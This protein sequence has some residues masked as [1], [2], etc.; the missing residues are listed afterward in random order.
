[1]DITPGARDCNRDAA[2]GFAAV[3]WLGRSG[4]TFTS[5]GFIKMTGQG[6]TFSDPWLQL[7]LTVIRIGESFGNGPRLLP[8]DIPKHSRQKSQVHQNDDPAKRRSPQQKSGAI[9]EKETQCGD[10]GET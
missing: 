1:V 5:K 10:R 9:G 8:Q 3:H 7:G 2:S 6:S 4:I